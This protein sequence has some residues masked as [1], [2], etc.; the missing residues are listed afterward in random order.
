MD[1]SHKVSKPVRFKK[2]HRSSRDLPRKGYTL[3]LLLGKNN[4]QQEE[5]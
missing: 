2:S 3:T 5:E 1:M 4:R